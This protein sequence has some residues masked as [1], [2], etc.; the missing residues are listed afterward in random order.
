MQV[1]N[2]FQT[3]LDQNLQIDPECNR[4]EYEV[5]PRVSPWCSGSLDTL[6]EIPF[7][8]APT[9]TNIKQILSVY[10]Y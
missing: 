3:L 8:T 4:M 5:I 9:Q 6:D 7:P 10:L 1:Q 2:K